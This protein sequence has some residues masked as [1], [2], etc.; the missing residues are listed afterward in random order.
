M[1]VLTLHGHPVATADR[2][3]RLCMAMAAYDNDDQEH[4]DITSNVEVLR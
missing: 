3:Q 4:M 1:Y 2:W